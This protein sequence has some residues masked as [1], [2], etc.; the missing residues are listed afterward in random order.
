MR[1]QPMRHL[2]ALLLLLAAGLSQTLGELAKRGVTVDTRETAILLEEISPST[3]TVATPWVFA[4]CSTAS[5][6]GV[7][8]IEIG[9]ADLLPIDHHHIRRPPGNAAHR[10][11]R[12][13]GWCAHRPRS[14]CATPGPCRGTLSSMPGTRCARNTMRISCKHVAV[15][16]NPGF[17]DADGDVDTA[18]ASSRLSGAIPDRRRKFELQLWQTCVPLSARHSISPSFSHTPWPSVR[19]E[20][21]RPNRSRYSTAVP[22]PRRVRIFFLIRGLQQ[23]HMQWRVIPRRCLREQFKRLVAAP[24]QIRGR[25][26]QSYTRLT[27]MLRSQVLK[28]LHHVGGAELEACKMT[29]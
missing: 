13:T 18:L 20:F 9:K 19:R 17:I 29:F 11:P 1:Q 26:L 3:I 28:H 21:S 6:T 27:G 8:S 5:N 15:V 22:P 25:Q 24:M 7:S 10:S 16:I 23:V 2:T 14:P 12:H 4:R